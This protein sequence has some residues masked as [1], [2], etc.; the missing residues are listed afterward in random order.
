MIEMPTDIQFKDELRKELIMYR[1]Y[2]ELLDKDER[3]KLRT[4]L[5][6]RFH[7]WIIWEI[8]GLADWSAEEYNSSNLWFNF[9]I[10]VPDI[11]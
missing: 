1:E 6:G 9:F 8:L 4:F 5:Y 10:V 2:L 11:S 3:E 7:C